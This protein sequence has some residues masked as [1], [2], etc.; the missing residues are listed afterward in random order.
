MNSLYHIILA[1]VYTQLFLYDTIVVNDLSSFL[2]H[3][4]YWYFKTVDVQEHFVLLFKQTNEY[5]NNFVMIYIMPRLNTFSNWILRCYAAYY[6]C[7]F[8]EFLALIKVIL[9]S[10]FRNYK[11][12]NDLHHN[13]FGFCHSNSESSL[14]IRS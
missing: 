12:I 7:C 4:Q 13:L 10:E 3:I 5:V 8:L 14:A 6:E 1:L 9:C 11:L 2:L